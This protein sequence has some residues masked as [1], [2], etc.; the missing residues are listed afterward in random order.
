M[1]SITALLNNTFV[2]AILVILALLLVAFGLYKLGEH[3]EKKINDTI[4]QTTDSLVK[5][6]QDSLQKS[7]D[8]RLDQFSTDLDGKI[9][10]I[11]VDFSNAQKNI[12]ATNT[13]L[14]NLG[15]VWLRVDRVQSG[16]GNVSNPTG[17][18]NKSTGSGSGS[19]GTYYAKLPDASLQFLKGEAYRADQCAVRLTSAQQ[20]LVQYK[21]AFEQYQQLVQTYLAAANVSGTAVTK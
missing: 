6:M 8:N 3:V 9:A 11:N 5:N 1:I 16:Q 18:G 10:S 12:D 13:K 14:N 20:V 4:Q 17:Q 2:R 7:M 19:D 21:G 15:D